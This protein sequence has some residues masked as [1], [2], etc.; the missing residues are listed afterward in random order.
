MSH[1]DV[2]ES[3]CDGD[4]SHSDVGVSNC[5]VVYRCKRE[6]CLISNNTLTSAWMLGL[7][8]YMLYNNIIYKIIRMRKWSYARNVT[9]IFILRRRDQVPQGRRTGRISGERVLLRRHVTSAVLPGRRPVHVLRHAVGA[10]NVRTTKHT[11]YWTSPLTVVFHSA[12]EYSRSGF[13]RACR[14][15]MYVHVMHPESSVTAYD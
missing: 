12:I 4:E 3:H 13:V 11:W 7:C 15:S 1:C 6:T 2:D 5:D 8:F 9:R 10:D 14:L